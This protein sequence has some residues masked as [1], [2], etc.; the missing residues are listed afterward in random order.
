MK[1][2]KCISIARELGFIMFCCLIIVYLINKFSCLI[3]LD[4]IKLRYIEYLIIGI[5]M[6]SFMAGGT[7]CQK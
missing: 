5:G 6:G 4:N 3:W 7:K 1:I 2:D